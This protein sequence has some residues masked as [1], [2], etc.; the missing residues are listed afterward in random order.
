MAEPGRDVPGGRLAGKV[1]LVVGGGQTQGATTGNGR[2]I[3]CRF[4]AEGA[5]VVVADRVLA[6]AEETVAIIEADGGRAIAIEGDITSS[7]DCAAMVAATVEAHGRMDVVVDNVGIGGGDGGPVSLEEHVWDRIQSVNV[8]G[9]YLLCKHV[10]PVLREQG[11]GS[12]VLVSSV[13]AVCSTGMLAYTT[14]KAALNALCHEVAMGN[15]GRGIRC[16]AVMPGLMDTPMAVDALAGALGVD[17]AVVS[18]RRDAMVPLG[19]QQGTADDVA[20]AVLFLASDEARFV[21]AAVLPVDG[22]QSARIG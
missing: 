22:G 14:S 10:L 12:I 21:T 11:S 2:A 16:N 4:A 1:A 19:G 7:D 9:A 20:N 5:S 13:A 15:A 17:R 18:E 3:S 8:K 6:R